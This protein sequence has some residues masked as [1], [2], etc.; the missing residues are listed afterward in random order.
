MTAKATRRTMLAA[1][2][3][4][5]GLRPARATPPPEVR[6]GILQFGT[7]QWVAEIIRRHALDSKHGFTLNTVTLAN[8][9]A[10]RISLMAGASDVVASD[11]PF[12]AVQRTAG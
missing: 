12:V 8:T 10:G 2:T 9:D 1:A 6:L 3:A 5:L 11:W 7:I 4:Y